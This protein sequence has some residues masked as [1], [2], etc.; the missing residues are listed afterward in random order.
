MTENNDVRNNVENAAL[1]AGD[2]AQQ[3]ASAA[4]SKAQEIAG[5]AGK[6]VDE[7]T[8]AL[9]ERVRSAAG[10][11][12]ERGPHDGVLGTATSAVADSLEHTGRY[13]KEEGLAGMAEDV[14]ELIR[15]NPIPAMLV[16]I[17]IGFVLAR[18]FRSGS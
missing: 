16:G 5:S 7:A 9:G 18:L 3:A 6:C 11:L 10:A 15:R 2:K 14:T 13:I 17:G 4:M 1:Q 8:A 12:R